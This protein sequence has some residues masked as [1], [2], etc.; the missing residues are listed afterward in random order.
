MRR[1][2]LLP[3]NSTLRHRRVVSR[4]VTP[5]TVGSMRVAIVSETFQSGCGAAV[6]DRALAF[7]A[8]VSSLLDAPE[9]ARRVAVRARA[10]QFT[11]SVAVDGML[12]AS[13]PGDA[14]FTAR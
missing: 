1:K 12:S 8:A 14:P 6:A 11:W 9:S 13:A 7:A 5:D 2:E 10:E 3:R 4:Q